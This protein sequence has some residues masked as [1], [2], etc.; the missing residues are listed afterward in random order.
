M[1]HTP[2][3][4][5]PASAVA[6][7]HRHRGAL[8]QGDADHRSSADPG[9][10]AGDVVSYNGYTNYETWAVSMFLDGNYDGDH[11]YFESQALFAEIH[12]TAPHKQAEALKDYVENSLSDLGGSLSGDLL[13]AALCNVNWIELMDLYDLRTADA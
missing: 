12:N 4:H 10:I 9:W 3:Q 7:Y 6:T 8:A 11:V 5:A 2:Q 13:R 1:T